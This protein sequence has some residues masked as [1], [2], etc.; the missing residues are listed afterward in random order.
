MPALGL[1]A[2]L[3]VAGMASLALRAPKEDPLGPLRQAK[4]KLES[5]DAEGALGLLNGAVLASVQQGQIGGDGVA[6][7]HLLRARATA[8]AQ[9]RLGVR[10]QENF[11]IVA[12]EFESARGAGALLE[13]ADLSVLAGALVELGRIDEALTLADTLEAEHPKLA[14]SLLEAVVE[15]NVAR[16]PQRADQTLAL[17]S[18]LAR[19]PTRSVDRRAWSLARETRLRLDAGFTQEGVARLL[20]MLPRLEPEPGLSAER[21]G[22]LL[23]LLGRGYYELG[24]AEQAAA[25]LER[26]VELLGASDPSRGSAELLLASMLSARGGAN[27]EH[28]EAARAQFARVRRAY[29]LTDLVGPALLGY[30]Q[31]SAALQDDTEALEAY[32]ELVGLVGG[33]GDGGGGP[34]VT[35]EQVASSLLERHK[36]RAARGE[37]LLALRYAELAERTWDDRAP[38]ELILGIARAHLALAEEAIAQ[39]T[40]AGQPHAGDDH[41]SPGHNSDHGDDHSGGSQSSGGHSGPHGAQPH[42]PG[43]AKADAHGG[44][45]SAAGGHS[46]AGTDAHGAPATQDRPGDDRTARLIPDALA[47]LSPVSATQARLHLVEAG[48]A[49]RRFGGRVVA[50][51][52]AAF[53]DALW[54]AADV[55]DRAGDRAAARESFSVFLEAAGEADPRRPE[56][57]FRVARLHMADGD[58]PTAAGR[59]R[60]IIAD[61]TAGGVG[62]EG[63]ATGIWADRSVVPL[64]RAVLSDPRS[65]AEQVGYVEALLHETLRGR[66]VR[67][68]S[69]EYRDA[70]VEL[71]ELQYELE[72][73]E[74]AVRSLTEAVQRYGAGLPREHAVRFKLADAHRRL[75]QRI[76]AALK[77]PQPKSQRDQRQAERQGHLRESLALFEALRQELASANAGSGGGTGGGGSL[78]RRLERDA[79]FAVGDCALE[80][81]RYPEAIAAYDAAAQRYAGDPSSLLALSQIVNAYAAQGLT[82]EARTANARAV[83][84]LSS[85]PDSAW[86]DPDLPMKREHWERWFAS[87]SRLGVESG[88][89]GG[90]QEASTARGLPG[91]GGGG[92]VGGVNEGPPE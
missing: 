10:S 85:L 63:V 33:A 41:S 3:L 31:T 16:A 71:G 45:Q 30:A 75:A 39:R 74:E 48:E 64:A 86:D 59:F 5:G 2:A 62:L 22:E 21:R 44:G 65:D 58:W 60:E 29:D 24:D 25:H 77:E 42:T 73:H 23:V 17:L 6:E 14:T 1:S 81:E 7:F 67:P 38:A 88:R 40:H 55:F 9:S 36:D 11:G 26:A 4:D 43:P 61:R 28:L 13:P 90:G 72:K 84:Y 49:F 70:L 56:A 82:S 53:I 15:H 27:G 54:S 78:M 12:E 20:R 8:Q 47:G 92:Q 76:A 68:E 18:R 83:R 80:L 19:D 52:P 89:P 50:E 79:W 66:T 51:D 69:P 87:A 35:R 34:G 46:G 57:R 91:L 37:P 32:G